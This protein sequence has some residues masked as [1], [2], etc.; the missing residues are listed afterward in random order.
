MTLL[1]HFAAV[2]EYPTP[3]LPDRVERCIDALGGSGFDRKAAKHMREFLSY[4]RRTDV[5]KMEEIYTAAFELQPACCLYIGHHLFADPRRRAA[6]MAGLAGRY[7]AGGL[8]TGGELPDHLPIV[9]RFLA[10]GE[11]EADNEKEEL[12][13]LCVRPAL[14]KM[15][16]SLSDQENPYRAALESLSAALGGADE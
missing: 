2:L 16:A 1:E 11:K 8:D 6:F 5:R 3:G 13:T 9:L 15:L 14:A 7:R 4:A 12:K 10:A